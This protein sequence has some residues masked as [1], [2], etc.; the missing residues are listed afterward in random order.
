M[1]RLTLPAAIVLIAIGIFS[2]DSCT[3]SKSKAAGE[4]SKAAEAARKPAPNFTLRDENGAAVSLAD[5]KGKVVL[6]NFW[7]TWC[8]PCQ[9]EIPWFEQ[10]EQQY[11][12]QGFAVLGVSMDD[13]GW[14]AVKPFVVT[15]KVN[16]RILLGND[17]IG[18][19]YGGLDALPTSFIIDREGRLAYTHVGLAGKNEYLSEIQSLLASKAQSAASLGVA[20]APALLVGAAE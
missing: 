18:Q 3:G 16:Y 12:S 9:I 2:F 17:S 7:A 20:A 19:L 6:L 8:G 1:R 15:H 5:Y 4:A 10:F 14:Q 13:D 11:K